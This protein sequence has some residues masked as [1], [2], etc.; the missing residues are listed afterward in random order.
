MITQHICG[1]AAYFSGEKKAFQLI[2]PPEVNV[3]ALRNLLQSHFI[4]DSVTKCHTQV[5][6]LCSSN[7]IHIRSHLQ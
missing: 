2:C 7:K 1:R 5:N 3:E 6:N 4:I